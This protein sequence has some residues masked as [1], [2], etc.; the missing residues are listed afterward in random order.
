MREGFICDDGI[1]RILI[2]AFIQISHIKMW[3]IIDKFH[4]AHYILVFFWFCQGMID[5]WI[6]SFSP[7][8]Y[9]NAQ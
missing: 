6:K 7:D 1:R 5:R 4:I 9:G 3:L 2:S 8:I